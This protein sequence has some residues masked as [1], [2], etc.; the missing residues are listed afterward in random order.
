MVSIRKRSF[1]AALILLLSCLSARAQVVIDLSQFEKTNNTRLKFKVLDSGSKEPLNF[2]SAYMIPAKDTIITHFSIS[3]KEGNVDMGEVV[4]GEYQLN[5]ELLGYRP[6]SKN[7]NVKGYQ[8]TLDDV[9]LEQDS[10]FLKAAAVSANVD[11]VTFDKDTIIFNAAAYRLG[12][13]AK[14]EDLLKLMPGMEVDEDGT[15]KVNGEKVDKITVGGKTFFFDDPN[16]TLKN[17]PAKFV[18]KIKVVDKQTRQAAFT[19]ADTKQDKEK[20]MDVVLKEEY[21][22]GSFGNAG[23]LGGVSLRGDET[24][25]LTEDSKPLFNASAMFANYNEQDQLTL[26][27]GG[28]NADDPTSSSAMAIFYG[29]EEE[30]DPL[31]GKSGL[32]TSAQAGVNYN[33]DRIKGYNSATSLSYNYLGKDIKELSD[34]QSFLSESSSLRSEN[35]FTGAQNT[36]AIKL[37]TELDRKK[38]DKFQFYL[39]PSLR[40]QNGSISS[41]SEGSNSIDG[42]AT[43]DSRSTYSSR[44][45]SLAFDIDIETG[46]RNFGKEGRYLLLFPKI[47]LKGGRGN[48]AENS[49]TDFLNSSATENLNLLYDN[50]FSNRK[51]ELDMAYCEPLVKNLSLVAQLHSDYNSKVVGKDAVNAID[52]TPNDYYSSYT[53]TRNTTFQEDVYLQYKIKAGSNVRLGAVARQIRTN[54][55]SRTMGVEKT[56]GGKGFTS[57]VAPNVSLRLSAGN[58]TGY[59]MY[60]SYSSLPAAEYLLGAID[61]TNPLERSIGNIYLGSSVNQNTYMQVGYSL[62]K[63]SFNTYVYASYSSSSRERVF[64]SWFDSNSVRYSIPVN[65]RKPSSTLTAQAVINTALDS[66]KRWFLFTSFNFSSRSAVSYQAKGRLDIVDASEFD[67]QSFMS[68]FWGDESGSKFY[69]GESGFAQSKT[70]FT[71]M[72]PIVSLSFRNGGLNLEATA[73]ASFM[74]SS[75][76]L[77][78]SA[79]TDWRNYN[80]SLRA[81]YQFNSGFSLNSNASYLMY[82]GYSDAV[83]RNEFIWNASIS[84]SFKSFTLSLK[85]IDLLGAKSNFTRASNAEYIQD[86]WRNTLGRYILVGISFDFGKKNAA[87]NSKAQSAMF[88]MLY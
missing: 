21:K 87:N 57:E 10:A 29:N 38:E 16:M 13:T 34:R 42:Q 12:E 74:K 77:D 86:T 46:V 80:F 76:S 56:A 72:N 30:Y 43:T 36:H 44:S 17:L 68:A 58:F 27:A 85:G 71:D 47:T 67:Y 35:S 1:A 22:K 31:Q 25:P 59:L 8:M 75:Y 78:S 63:K 84:K 26:I 5:V 60:Q 19:G 62:P 61:L 88:D 3:D 15:V 83:D 6:F 51:Y 64:A 50:S 37:S 11:P 23:V 20:V 81:G 24:N 54:T 69:N 65:S 79:D 73:R 45:N 7:I 32:N 49:R 33:T 53:N 4:A 14:L 48:S 28:K 2:V 18:D 52:S 82:Q 70:V 40:F 66:R 41:L 9:L 55:F 39:Y